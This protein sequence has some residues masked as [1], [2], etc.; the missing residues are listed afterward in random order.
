MTGGVFETEDEL[1]REQQAV[2]LR[3]PS[4]SSRCSWRRS[5]LCS[6]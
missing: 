5:P 2:R 3:T 4:E 1:L 6:R